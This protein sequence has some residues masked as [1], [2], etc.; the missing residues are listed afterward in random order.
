MTETD[1]VRLA[2]VALKPGLPVEVHVQTGSRTALS[3][4]LKP[5]TDSN[6]RGMTET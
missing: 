2:A 5:I 4:L 6:K 1:P 3:Y